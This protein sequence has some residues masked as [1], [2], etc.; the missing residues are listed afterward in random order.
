M[1]TISGA[2]AMVRMLQLH[3]VQHIFGLCGDT[4]LPLYDALY[5]LDHGMQHILARDERSAA[6]MAD[7]YARISGRVGVCEGPSG[8]GATYILPGLVEAN[9]S[10]SPLLAITTDVSVAARGTFPLTELD[11]RTLFRPVTKWNAMIDLP[12]QIPL[13]VRTAFQRM[14]TGKP[15]ATHLGFPFDVQRGEVNEADIWADATLGQVPSYRVAPPG[16]EVERM[17]ALLRTAQRP[18]LVCGGGPI[19]AGACDEVQRLAELLAAPVATSVSGQGV[20]ADTHPLALG[21]VGSNGGTPQTRD[22]LMSADTV[23]FIGCRAG[24]VTTERSRFPAPGHGKILHIDVDPDVIGVNYATDAALVGDA[25]LAL[26]ALCEALGNSASEDALHTAYQTVAA[27]KQEKFEIFREYA[28]IRDGLIRPETV[29]DALQQHTPAASIIVADPG[30]PCPYFS[31]YYEHRQA[32]RYFVTNRAHG[33]LGYALPGVVGAQFARPNAKCIAVMGD[34]S[35]GFSCGEM[36]TI[37]RYQLPVTLLVISNAVFG[38]IKAGQKSGFNQRYFSVDFRR[39]EHARVAEAFGVKAW[40][41]EDPVQLHDTVQQALATDGPTLVDI[42]CQPL[43]E[44]HA[45]VS[46]WI[47]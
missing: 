8:G 36:E 14:T 41:V 11:Q 23:V 30:T 39:T 22:V 45:P 46:E 18:L 12:V 25:K 17:A 9:D 26:A 15:G 19:I 37:V 40:R 28:S 42:I 44:A 24:S 27:A 5:R 3:G 10:S 47:S 33:A 21:V 13:L 2:E 20:I 16:S 1:T 6:Y 4:S 7:V 34:G 31:G 43:H 32:G 35:F 29:I 38:W